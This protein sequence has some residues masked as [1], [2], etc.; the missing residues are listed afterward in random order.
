ME[1]KE[2]K[3]FG[4]NSVY[5][6]RYIIKDDEI[7]YLS[8]FGNADLVK[9]AVSTLISNDEIFINDKRFKRCG[10]NYTYLQKR[11]EKGIIHCVAY[12]KDFFDFHQ[13]SS[14]AVVYDYDKSKIFDLVD[15]KVNVPLLPE[16]ADMIFDFV[17]PVYLECFGFKNAVEIEIPEE[18]ALKDEVIRYIS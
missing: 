8:L 13:I 17:S 15:S 9:G 10:R 4:G 3:F 16:W 14:I 18:Q 11:L 12:V 1:Y 6:D 5:T 7:L 2:I